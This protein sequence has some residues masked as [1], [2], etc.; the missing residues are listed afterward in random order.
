MKSK[1]TLILFGLIIFYLVFKSVNSSVFLKK[2]DRVNVIFYGQNSAYFSLSE[3]DVNYLVKFSPEMEMLVPGGYGKYKLGGLGKL[4]SLE[5]KPDLF[6]KTFSAATSTFVDLY[7]F[8]R[9]TEIYYQEGN[10]SYFP[11]T[12]DIF[13]SKSNANFVDRLILVFKL[14]DRNQS[15]FRVISNLPKS[16]DREEF[17]KDFQGNFYK[18]SFRS[19]QTTVQIFYEKSYSTSLLLSEIISGEGIRVVDISQSDEQIGKCQI[20]T[21]KINL[22]SKALSSYFGCQVNVGETIISDIIFKLG[23]LE[24]DWA[25]K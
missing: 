2:K 4:V 15:K 9:K 12:D 16:F 24:K 19:Q 13:F 14:F 25:V 10:Q 5:K 23:S 18:R 20:I 6:R 17:Y 11:K 21:N 22:I 7:F 1:I 3:G 8:P